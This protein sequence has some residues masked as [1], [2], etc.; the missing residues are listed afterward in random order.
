MHQRRD[1]LFS[2]CR[3]DKQVER[4][5][6]A[7]S[8]LVVVQHGVRRAVRDAGLDPV[9]VEQSDQLVEAPVRR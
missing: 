1:G 3:R 7:K 2:L 6:E 8:G 4:V 5:V 9:S